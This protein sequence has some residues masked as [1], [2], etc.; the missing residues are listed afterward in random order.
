MR[1]KDNSRLI[2]DMR[3]HE[4]D[5]FHE[6]GRYNYVN[7]QT[8][9]LPHTHP[10]MLEICYLAKGSQEYFV[11]EN[12]FKLYGGDVFISFPNE[13]HGTGNAPEEKGLLYWMI[14][15]QPEEGK[16]YLGLH[17]S[18]AK[19]LFNRLLLLPTR[20]FRGNIECERLL[21]SIIR[22]YFQNRDVL[23]K[24][25]LNN[26]LVSFLLHIIHSG[27]KKQTRVYSE[28]ITEIIQYIDDNLFDTLD[29][30]DLADKCNLSVSRFK[31]LFKEETGIPPAEYIIRKKVEKAQELIE[32]QEQSI[33]D[34][35]YDLG[36]SSPAYF[37]TVFKQYNGYSPTSLKVKKKN[38]A[39]L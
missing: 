37:S 35:A 11:N 12:A 2:L 3:K 15:K 1:D 16:E 4:I 6:F 10:D 33:K 19:V 22:T 31:H 39:N 25:E 9:L 27:E 8:V 13:V 17:F 29:L 7:V 38:P 30:E 18:E 23:T 28:R 36:F 14:L 26:L 32:K 20:L 5:V 34:I 24:I 21:Q